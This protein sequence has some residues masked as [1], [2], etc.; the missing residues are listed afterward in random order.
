MANLDGLSEE[1][2]KRVQALSDKTKGDFNRAQA[3]ERPRAK[4]APASEQRRADAT[5]N[6]VLTPHGQTR[7]EKTP[8]GQQREDRARNTADR[9]NARSD[10][11]AD[12]A[13]KR[14]NVRKEFNRMRDRDRLRERDD[15]E[16]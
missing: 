11:S 9:L 1:E 15:F 14:A 5:V 3:G 13:Q 12:N 4:D 8:Q 16:R 6:H 7:I 10:Q 2:R